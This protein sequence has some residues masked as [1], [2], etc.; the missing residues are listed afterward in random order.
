MNLAEVRKL[1]PEARP[2]QGHLVLEGKTAGVSTNTYFMFVDG[3]LAGVSVQSRELRMSAIQYMDDYERFRRALTQ[4]YGT[5]H[6]DGPVWRD[7]TFKDI[8]DGLSTALTLGHAHLKTAWSTRESIVSLAAEGE[9]LR[10]SVVVTYASVR[11][12]AILMKSINTSEA[13]EM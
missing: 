8:P 12:Y 2:A 6:T 1:Y 13:D 9:K 3:R 10:I 5:P 11:L 4:K 7:E